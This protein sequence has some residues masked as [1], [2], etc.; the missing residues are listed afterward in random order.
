MTVG[1]GHP[2]MLECS[3]EEADT[4]IV[5]HIVHALQQGMRK[6]E[7]RTVDTHIIVILAGVYFKLVMAYQLL[8][9]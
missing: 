5:V 6:I 3:H 2:C 9:I 1:S 8:D 4:R 7:I